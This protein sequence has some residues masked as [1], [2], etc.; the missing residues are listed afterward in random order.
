VCKRQQGGEEN[1]LAQKCQPRLSLPWTSLSWMHCAPTH[2]TNE[3]PLRE[4]DTAARPKPSSRPAAGFLVVY[5]YYP[6]KIP[7]PEASDCPARYVPPSV[8]TDLAARGHVLSLWRFLGDHHHHQGLSQWTG[9]DSDFIHHF[10]HSAASFRMDHSGKRVSTCLLAAWLAAEHMSHDWHLVEGFTVA[11]HCSNLSE[12]QVSSVYSLLS[13]EG[14]KGQEILLDAGSLRPFRM[15][16]RDS[17]LREAL[18]SC[19]PPA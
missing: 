3:Q 12:A 17:S 8:V 9:S 4:S 10:C 18:R 6:Q 1:T 15:I 14:K 7:P 2:R 16:S 5:I 11:G 19:L 13:G